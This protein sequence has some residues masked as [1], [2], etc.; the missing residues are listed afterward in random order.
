MNPY[1]TEMIP[2]STI[3]YG[4]QYHGLL[5][6]VK[7]ET[8]LKNRPELQN[9]LFLVMKEQFVVFR[10]TDTILSNYLTLPIEEKIFE[11]MRRNMKK[12]L[13][14]KLANSK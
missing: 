3:T 6:M 9:K 11:N 14:S 10:V 1:M 7:K 12:D 13:D 8:S 2:S 4:S 5:L